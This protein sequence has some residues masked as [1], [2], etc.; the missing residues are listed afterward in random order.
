MT[1]IEITITKE[2]MDK[3]ELEKPFV[4]LTSYD[5]IDYCP[6]AQAIRRLTNDSYPACGS[7][8]AIVHGLTY[9]A[10]PPFTKP[11]YHLL[12]DRLL[13]DPHSTFTTTLIQVE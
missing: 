12:K 9:S 5:S 11:A 2:D 1:T 6:L 8:T 7:L 3:A 10:T 4:V 13:I